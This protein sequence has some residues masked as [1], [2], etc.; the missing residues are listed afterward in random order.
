MAGTQQV[1]KKFGDRNWSGDRTNTGLLPWL[2]QLPLLK[3][4]GP[5]VQGWYCPQRG[6]SA[7]S[8]QSAIKKMSHGRAHKLI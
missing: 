7:L 5:P 6:W 1:R 4:P 3:D 2:A 8:H